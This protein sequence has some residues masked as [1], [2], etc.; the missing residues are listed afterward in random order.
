MDKNIEIMVATTL[1]RFDHELSAMEKIVGEMRNDVDD[2]MADVDTVKK[3]INEL[4]GGQ[5]E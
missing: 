3:Y 5:N 4:K 2:L 1:E